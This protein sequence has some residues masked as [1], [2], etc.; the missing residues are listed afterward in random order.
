MGFLGDC[1]N[2][3][4]VRS[5]SVYPAWCV[6]AMA[7]IW[8]NNPSLLPDNRDPGIGQQHADS[9][10]GPGQRR[11]EDTDTATMAQYVHSV[12]THRRVFGGGKWTII[13]DPQS[14]G[15]DYQHIFDTP[16]ISGKM[17]SLQ[18]WNLARKLESPVSMRQVISYLLY[19]FTNLLTLCM[20]AN[21]C[22]PGLRTEIHSLLCA[23][24]VLMIMD[25]IRCIAI[26][27]DIKIIRIK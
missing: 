24:V 14:L 6:H 17:F 21:F 25:T 12:D 3:W 9:E 2:R 7:L 1:G 27:T 4:I 8:A 19:L 23:M 26:M 15:G 20:I 11:T 22:N 18:T 5:S 13:G 16:S 10:R